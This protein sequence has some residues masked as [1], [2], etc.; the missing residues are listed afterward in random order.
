MVNKG[1]FRIHETRLYGSNFSRNTD[2]AEQKK[3]SKSF[4]YLQK[5]LLEGNNI[6]KVANSCIWS[7]ITLTDTKHYSRA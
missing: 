2:F 5:I 6:L 4:K 1:T 7:F 3:Y